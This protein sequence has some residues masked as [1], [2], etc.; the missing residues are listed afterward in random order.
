MTQ[1]VLGHG[2]RPDDQKTF[3]P[4]GA[5]LR[6][7][8]EVEVDLS[9][10]V[11]LTAAADGANA[12]A[13][14]EI[15][16]TG[17]IGDVYNYQFWR[18]E[19]EYVAMAVA[20]G[21]GTTMPIT[22]VGDVIP[23][24]ARLCSA[25]DQ[26]SDTHTC[27]GLLGLF[28]DPDLVIIACRGFVYDDAA[29]TEGKYGKDE[30][31]PLHDIEE[32]MGRL[33]GEILAQAVNDPSGAEARVDDLP[34]GTVALMNPF[35]AFVNWQKARRLK[36]YA[37][38]ADWDQMIGHLT[39]NKGDLAEIMACL[40]EY[41]SYGADFDNAI[42]ANAQRVTVA[43]TNGSVAPEVIEALLTRPAVVTATNQGEGGD[44]VP[45]DSDLDAVDSRNQ[46]NIK[47]AADKSTI[48]LV[49]GGL[50]VIAGSGHDTQVVQYVRR[51]GDVESGRVTITKGGAFTKG[52]LAVDG[53]SAKQDLVTQAFGRVSD[54]KV[55]FS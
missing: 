17:Q 36:E 52:T 26:C 27:D 49:A 51:Q 29:A 10:V 48:D 3:L 5:K 37:Q 23:D 40:N 34:Q 8:S 11:G 4:V 2:G 28:P 7:Y 20:L 33:V 24:E 54:K 35:P 47:A 38:Q 55:T 31:N 30:E 46:G 14:E 12:E 22:F 43:L 16:G 21:A 25:P 6:Y 42:T 50:L 19:D 45:T 41:P 39:A 1:I 13:K 15:T 32:D 9:S 44:W 53:I 18:I